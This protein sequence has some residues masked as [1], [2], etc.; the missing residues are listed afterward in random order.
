MDKTLAW[1]I[2][3]RLEGLATGLSCEQDM[4]EVV[5][6]LRETIELLR[7]SVMDLEET[8]VL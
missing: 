8:N 7:D 6:F 5:C 1:A 4:R 2:I 3:G